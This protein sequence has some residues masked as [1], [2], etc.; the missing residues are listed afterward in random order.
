MG[1]TLRV[2]RQQDDICIGLADYVWHGLD[3]QIHAK[4]RTIPVSMGQDGEYVPVIERWNTREKDPKDPRQKVQLVLHPAHYAPDPMRPQPSYVVIC[5]VRDMDDIPVPTNTRAQLRKLV[6]QE[7]N[8]LGLWWGIHQ[9]YTIEPHDPERDIRIH[10]KHIRTCV[11]SGILFYGAG[12][13]R[14]CRQFQIGPR[15]ISDSDSPSDA[16]VVADHLWIALYFLLRL[17]QQDGRI[18]NYPIGTTCGVYLS[19]SDMR[20]HHSAVTDMVNALT[21]AGIKCSPCLSVAHRRH[22]H[23]EC[24]HQARSDPYEIMTDILTVLCGS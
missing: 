24:V 5:E 4:T 12:V 1:P 8:R 17:A 22:V 14:F 3:G 2:I 13:A 9:D 21:D 6:D 20:A 19:T 10:E 23:V 7:N 15:Q 18:I 16:L 11:D